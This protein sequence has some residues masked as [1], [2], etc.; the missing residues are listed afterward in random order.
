MR[1]H[2]YLLYGLSTGSISLG[3]LQALGGIN[4]NQLWYN[5]LT[6]LLTALVTLLFGGDL[7]QL[8]SG[9]N[10]YGDFSSLFI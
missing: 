3:I 5:F 8:L 9:L 4:F 7:S 1:R 10:L 6:T 2:A